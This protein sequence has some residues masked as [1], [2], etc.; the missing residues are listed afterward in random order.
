MT[1]IENAL[2]WLY[3]KSWEDFGQHVLDEEE[4]WNFGV[5]DLQYA[6]NGVFQQNK[7]DE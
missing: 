5:K 1:K 3:V 7:N 4:L 2:A 6:F